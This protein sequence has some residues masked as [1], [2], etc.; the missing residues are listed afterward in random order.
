MDARDGSCSFFSLFAGI[1]L[2]VD[3]VHFIR[4]RVLFFIWKKVSCFTVIAEKLRF[5]IV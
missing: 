4:Q 2:Y 3:V 5:F 1:V